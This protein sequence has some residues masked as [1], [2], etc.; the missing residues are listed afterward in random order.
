[1]EGLLVVTSGEPSLKFHR[2]DLANSSVSE[3]T[4]VK[5]TQPDVSRGTPLMAVLIPPPTPAKLNAIL[6]ANKLQEL[7]RLVVDHAPPV[8]M[9]GRLGSPVRLHEHM[10]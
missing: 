5:G 9:I 7:L 3:N 1:M 8:P 4:T 6:I 2:Y 10:D